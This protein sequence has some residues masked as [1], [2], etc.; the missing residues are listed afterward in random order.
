VYAAALAHVLRLPTEE[1]LMTAVRNLG[2]RPPPSGAA[3]A[4]G[5]VAELRRELRQVTAERDDLIERAARGGVQPEQMAKL[6]RRLRDQG[7]RLR[8][9]DDAL[10]AARRDA[11]GELAG[12]RAELTRLT[13]ELT[14]SDERARLATERADRAQESLGRMREQSTM[15]KATADRRIDLLLSTAEGAISGLRREWQLTGGGLTPAD[16]VAG[17]LPPAKAGGHGQSTDEPAQLSAWLG[18]PAAHLVVDGYNVSKTG[19]AALTLAGQRDRLIRSL[20][21][22][23]ARNSAEITVVFDGAAV[24]V[25]SSP[26]RGVRVIFSPPGVIADDIIRE[27]VA[28]EPPGRV[29]VVVSSDREVA[30]RVRR[31][32]ARTA[33]SDVLLALLG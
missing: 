12:L 19:F 2:A 31:L 14:R 9:A 6:Q 18:L 11:A 25:P 5:T 33:N 15:D 22:L 23:S 16:V 32:G 3:A 28:A 24:A 10:E 13:S 30:D 29:V 21:V 4:S 17:R 20:A 8:L 1:E 27:L 26:G 7:T